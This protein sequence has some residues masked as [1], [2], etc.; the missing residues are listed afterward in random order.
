MESKKPKKTIGLLLISTGAYDQF[1]QPLI[2]SVDT[3]FFPD[4]DVIIYLFGDKNYYKF[5]LPSRISLVITPIEHRPWPASTLFRY[6]HFTDAAHKMK[7]CDYLFYSDADMIMVGDVTH[8]VLFV[9]DI[10][11]DLIV[12]RHPGFWNNKDWGSHNCSQWS[13]AYLGE[14]DRHTYVCGGFNGGTTAS[15]LNMAEIL[16]DNIDD[17]YKR[18]VVCEHNDENHINWFINLYAPTKRKEIIVKQLTP[19]Y[20]MVPEV[21]VREKF[22]IADLKPIIYAISKNHEELR[23]H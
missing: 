18:G 4:D 13:N 7:I 17:D 8:E 9:D 16:A 21:E 11:T 15:F 20:C 14:A 10:R 1:L 6:R 19:S 5:K 23:K 2:E 22:G 3:H 12:T